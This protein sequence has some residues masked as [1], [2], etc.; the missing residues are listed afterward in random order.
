MLGELSEKLMWVDLN[1]FYLVHDR[2][3]QYFQ[4]TLNLRKSFRYMTARV[5]KAPKFLES[6]QSSLDKFQSF[7]NVFKMKT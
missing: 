4:R 6:I 2:K 1:V 3:Q 7:E 5:L